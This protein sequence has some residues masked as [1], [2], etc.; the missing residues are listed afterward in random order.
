MTE[1][2][3]RRLGT[4]YRLQLTQSFD[5]AAAV[6]VVP[7]LSSLGVET[8]YLSPIFEARPGSE[9]G[10]DGTDPTAIRGELGG[11]R[12]FEAL[13]TDLHAAGLT[14][15]VDI[16]PNHLSTFTGGPWWRDVL[17]L[18][19]ASTY[20][21]VFDISWRSPELPREDYDRVIL[22]VLGSSLD[23]ALTAGELSIVGGCE[24]EVL[25]YRDLE[26]PLAPQGPRDL[27]V[28]SPGPRARELLG[29]QHYRLGCWREPA[30]N[31]RRFFSID[32][33]VGVRVEDPAVFELTHSLIAELI[34]LH[35]IDA[36]RVDH[37]DG[38]ADPADY[39][40]RLAGLAGDCPIVVE[41][42][43][44]GDEC[45]RTSWPVSGTTGYEV[46]NDITHV[47]ADAA[48]MQRLLAKAMG[49]G[50]RPVGD[51]IEEAKSLVVRASFSSEVKRVAGL[52]KIDEAVVEASCVAMPV[53][54]TYIS[55]RGAEAID[56]R[57]LEQAGGSELGEACLNDPGD[58][59]LE[60]VLRFQQLTGAVMAKGV[61]DTAWYRLVGNLPFLEV[62]GDPRIGGENGDDGLDRMHRRAR[63]RVD[64]GERGLIPG[65]THDTKRSADV[66][67]RL[68]ALGAMTAGFE[69]G[70]ARFRELVP[71]CEVG[72]GYRSVPDPLERRRLAEICLAMSPFPGAS[73]QTWDAIASRIDA[74]LRKG[75]R[76]E[77]ARDSWDKVNGAYEDALTA[78]AGELLADSGS[79]LR[80][81]FG[82]LIAK[83]QAHA[84][85]L[86]LGQV[87]LRSVLPGV[88]DCYQGDEGWNFALVD[89][90]NRRPVDYSELARTLGTLPHPMTPAAVSELRQS[91]TDGRVKLAVTRACLRLRRAF[92]GA[93]GA[94]SLYEALEVVAPARSSSA[95]PLVALVRGGEDGR[96]GECVIVVV[97]RAPHR[98]AAGPDDLPVGDSAFGD[99]EVSLPGDLVAR[100]G[101]DWTDVISGA[102]LSLDS[103]ARTIRAADILASLPVSILVPAEN[104]SRSP[105]ARS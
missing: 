82:E 56:R 91:W 73:A 77:K 65:T 96:Y 59:A 71:P 8:A 37:V 19:R 22:P 64:R 50:E 105:H 100:G 63:A 102:H 68:V 33:L 99:I 52:L 32:D 36:L 11:R 3:R 4:T 44:T 87:V 17:C 13:V 20:A 1:L 90:D 88:P 2:G 18:G 45:L 16:V 46:T 93:F 51:V 43:L 29:A 48:G 104:V 12:S 94:R 95:G 55:R 101:L 60:G 61:E 5:F 49:D 47:F 14:V 98:L 6:A 89:P 78:A 66:R 53:Y 76:E 69:G 85:T 26:L 7:Y 41:K 86:A 25:R 38:M 42:I 58:E 31:Y 62:G 30:R 79:L 9:H 75:A 28:L 15:L 97:T 84:A 40:G 70:L 92:P 34:G 27:G 80:E 39:L 67:A 57:L 81:C 23:E 74:A 54:R 83:M 24:G 72:D 103:G 21:P 35:M 10:Y